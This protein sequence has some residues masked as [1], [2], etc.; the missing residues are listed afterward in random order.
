[1]FPDA[2]K[3]FGANALEELGVEM[4]MRAEEWAR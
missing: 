4:E 2:E 1:M 3:E